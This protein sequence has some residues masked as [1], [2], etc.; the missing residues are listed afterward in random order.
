[1]IFHFLNNTEQHRTTRLSVSD[2]FKQNYERSTQSLKS[3]MRASVIS[4][5]SDVYWR[6]QSEPPHRRSVRLFP[7]LMP[8]EC[9]QLDLASVFASC[10]TAKKLKYRNC[11]AKFYKYHQNR[12]FALHCREYL[13]IQVWQGSIQTLGKCQTVLTLKH[14]AMS[15]TE[16]FWYPHQ[17]SSAGFTCKYQHGKPEDCKLIL[18]R[19]RR[20]Y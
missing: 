19:R 17:I 7:I 6:T 11:I 14:M 10:S 18:D 3:V 1:M 5:N 13:R 15:R 16:L 9:S 20:S 8:S 4:N 12:L 2:S